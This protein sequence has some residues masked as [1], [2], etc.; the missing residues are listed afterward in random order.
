MTSGIPQLSPWA[1][2]FEGRLALN[3]GFFMLCSK[4]FSL[5]IFC[6]SFRAS[7]HQSVDKKN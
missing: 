5:I 4:A 7:N 6:A 3:P 1:E 2:L